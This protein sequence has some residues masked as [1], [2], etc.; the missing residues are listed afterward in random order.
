M[1]NTID[2]NE[3]RRELAPILDNRAPFKDTVLIQQGNQ[4]HPTR[5]TMHNSQLEALADLVKRQQSHTVIGIT[6]TKIEQFIP[7]T[8]RYCLEIEES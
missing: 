8:F 2:L 6:L 7:E 5:M 3:M 4:G 1:S